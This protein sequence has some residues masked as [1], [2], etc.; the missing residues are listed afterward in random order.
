MRW[1]VWVDEDAAPQRFRQRLVKAV[2]KGKG[3]VKAWFRENVGR[4]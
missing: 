4:K 1:E 2:K 3:R